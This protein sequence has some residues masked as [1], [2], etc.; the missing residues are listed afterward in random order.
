MKIKTGL[1]NVGYLPAIFAVSALNTSE[2]KKELGI[3]A[4]M[5]AIAP[6]TLGVPAAKIP[7]VP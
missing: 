6:I 2:W 7:A 3:P 4:E 1:F 5:T